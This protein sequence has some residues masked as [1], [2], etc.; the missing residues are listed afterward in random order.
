MIRPEQ[1]PSL[2]LQ[3]RMAPQLIQSLRLL[4]MSTV[5]LALEV[6]QQ[7]E[8]NPLLEEAVELDE[9]G[10]EELREREE[11]IKEEE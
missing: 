7:L 1:N 4:Q 9:E 2:R 10:E 6:K 11:G 5:D 8:L 3:Q